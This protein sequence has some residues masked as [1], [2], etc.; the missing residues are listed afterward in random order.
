MGEV[1]VLGVNCMS[2]LDDARGSFLGEIFTFAGEYGVFFFSSS[3][4]SSSFFFIMAS[5]ELILTGSEFF[6]GVGLT[7]SSD[8]FPLR[9]NF[10]GLLVLLAAGFELIFLGD[11]VGA[12]FSSEPLRAWRKTHKIIFN[13][14]QPQK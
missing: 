10:D 4:L 6:F 2:E 9:V 1:S 13:N 8:T 5:L 11:A 14:H 3:S 7:A 12:V